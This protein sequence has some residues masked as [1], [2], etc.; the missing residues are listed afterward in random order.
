MFAILPEKVSSE[1]LR[2]RYRDF[3]LFPTA[4]RDIALVVDATTPAE[5]VR[6][7][8]AKIGR[9]VVPTSI[10]VESVQIFDVYHGKGLPEA[11]KSLAFSFVFRAPDRTLT[12]AE[13]NAAFQKIQEE[14]ARTTP[15]TL[16]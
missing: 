16:R 9:A 10:V 4:L 1:T 3:S 13:V 7:G 12:D 8:L 11:K 5:E 6:K 15:W 14:L 2:K